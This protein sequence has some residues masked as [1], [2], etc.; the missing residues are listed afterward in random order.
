MQAETAASS[1]PEATLVETPQKTSSIPPLIAALL[2]PESYW[3]PA[4]D[5]QLHETHISWVILAGPFAYKIKKPVDFGFL[6][7]TT[8]ERRLADCADEIRLNRR[9][10]PDVYLGIVDVV[11]RD[12]GY[13]LGGPGRPVEPAVWMRR[14]PE[15]GMLPTILARQVV[16]PQLVRRI[17]RQLAQFHTVAA[18]GPGVDAYGSLATVRANWDENFAQTVR[19]VGRTIPPAIHARIREFVERFLAD[20]R[21]LLERRVAG[22]RIREGHGDLHAG[23]ICVEGRRVHLFDCLEFAPRFRCSDVAAEV[24]FLAM[25][26]DHFGRADLA[27]DFVDEYVRRSG[28]TELPRL[29][30]FYKCYRAYVRGKVTCLRLDEPGLSPEGRSG[31][32]AEARA[33]FDLVW[34][35]AGGLGG[36]T[37]VVTMGLPASGKTTL[38]RGLARRLGLVH[39]SSD[40]VRKSLAG[41]RPTDRR[42]AAFGRGIYGQ[43]MTRRTYATIRRRAERWLRRGSSV[44]VDATFGQVAERDAIRRV[45]ARSGARLCVLV[46]QADEATIRRRLAAREADVLDAS[47]ARLDIWPALRAAY[48]APEEADDAVVLDATARPDLVLHRAIAAVAAPAGTECRDHSTAP[49]EVT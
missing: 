45:A 3:H 32:E 31:I 4:D 33:Y 37:I 10:C 16:G 34:A 21:E 13:F 2:R 14:L 22:G 18:T 9:L 48:S 30:D 38:A 7:F 5:I 8:R 26:L 46:C 44:V 23:S 35:Y 27:A 20:N 19:F 11:E 49:A 6:D 12:G 17:A 41:L 47:D 29:L 42:V 28:D 25:D 1:T 15:R 39:L 40:V 24:A 36:P 43:S